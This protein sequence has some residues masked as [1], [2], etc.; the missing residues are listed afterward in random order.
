MEPV[1]LHDADKSPVR[2]RVWATEPPGV[3]ARTPPL[4]DLD[5]RNF[6]RQIRMRI[7][8][9]EVDEVVKQ[10]EDAASFRAHAPTEFAPSSA[11]TLD[12][13]RARD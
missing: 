10:I 2:D 13:A 3:L 11:G 7:K 9:R 8:V 5:Q 1:G 6:Q 4:F 12:E